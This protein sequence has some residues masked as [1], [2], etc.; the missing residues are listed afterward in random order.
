[1]SFE[2]IPVDSRAA[3]QYLHA[4]MPEI[5]IVGAGAIGCAVAAALEDAGH[6]VLLCTRRPLDERRVRRPEGM[7]V[8]RGE[9][10]LEPG[11]APAVD[12]VLVAT[13][14][15]D[16]P[17]AASWLG[18]L[19]AR[20][21]PVA[22][23]QNGV[24]HRERFA[25]FVSPGSIVPVVVDCPASRPPSGPVH[26]RAAMHLTIPDTE[27]GRAF[28]ALFAGTAVRVVP[29]ADFA[30]VAWRKLSL[31]AVGVIPALVQKPAGVL[32]RP[33]MA[34]VALQIARECVAVARA[35]GVGLEDAV[36]EETVRRALASAPDSVN[37]LL[38]DR[39]AGRPL[40]LDARNGVIVRLGTKHGVAT[41]ANRMA[42]ALLEAMVAGP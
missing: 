38:A 28:A 1:M 5:A 16:A 8:L 12:W 17:G 25:P 15:H 32:H 24:E 37:S 39:L 31:N 19:R 9:N 20:H 26:Q 40:E 3:W 21:A 22:V 30:A 2:A 42:V 4:A 10:L 6:A 34:E 18:R 33:G 29:T 7:T 14:A 11:A 13:K 35:E 36:A 27:P 23:L 41:P